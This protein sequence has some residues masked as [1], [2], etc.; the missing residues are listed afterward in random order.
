MEQRQH[1]RVPIAFPIRLKIGNISDFTEE[2]TKNLSAGGIFV[3]MNYPPPVGTKV[4]MVFQ[5]EAVGKTIEAAGEVVRS[6]PE[7]TGGSDDAGMGIQFRDL[8]AEGKRFIELVV[9]KFNRNHP[10]QNV[11]LPEGFL[12]GVER[13]LA[14]N[15]QEEGGAAATNLEIRIRIP[16]LDAYRKSHI[17]SLLKGEVF[18][19]T[20]KTRPVGTNVDLQFILEKDNR[21][22]TVPGKIARVVKPEEG[23]SRPGL[24]IAITEKSEDF[25]SYLLSVPAGAEGARS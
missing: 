24:T 11:E 8:G 2:H 14:V 13:E 1:Q 18:I 22:I 6:I 15:R 5:L 19:P 10:S 7:S 20:K 16:D 23:G 4:R 3:R 21:W 9:D 25:Q 17:E 12:D